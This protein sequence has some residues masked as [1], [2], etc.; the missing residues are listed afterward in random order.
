MVRFKLRIWMYR[1]RSVKM[2]IPGF[3]NS[4]VTLARNKTGVARNL[5]LWPETIQALKEV[6]RSQQLVFYT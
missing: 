6:P 2:E 4:S 3:E 5:P 1:F